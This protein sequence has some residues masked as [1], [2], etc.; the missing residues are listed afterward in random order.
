MIRIRNLPQ[1]EAYYTDY[2]AFQVDDENELWVCGSFRCVK[3]RK[4]SRPIRVVRVRDFIYVMRGALDGYKLK[5]YWGQAGYLR[6]RD[7]GR[8]EAKER[9]KTAKDPG[10]RWL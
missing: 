7:P 8:V 2:R 3:E 1:T 10:F 4:E 5:R 9:A 6:C